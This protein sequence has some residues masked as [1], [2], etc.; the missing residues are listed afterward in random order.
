MVQQE[1][2]DSVVPI[3]SRARVPDSKPRPPLPQDLAAAIDHTLLRPEAVPA[4]VDRLCEEAVRFGF[5]TVCVNPVLVEQAAS[6]LA[7]TGVRAGTVA[8]FPLGADLSGIK[9]EEARRAIEIGAGEI[10]MVMNIGAMKAQKFQRV[11]DDIRAV[12]GVCAAGGALLKVILETA[13]LADSEKVLG[14]LLAREAGAGFVKTSTGFASAGATVRDIAI[15]R[16]AV[17]DTLGIKA[18][19][20]IRTLAQAAA[21]MHAGATRIGTSTGVRIMEE[22]EKAAV[23]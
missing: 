10:D 13:L 14:A 15:L 20:G 9:A 22:L 5:A 19:G 12:A 21:M 17:G 3:L 1:L 11:E 8:G 7:G 16:A 6:R 23:R 2:L 4:D 18:S